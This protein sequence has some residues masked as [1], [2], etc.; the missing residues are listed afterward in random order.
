[1][2]ISTESDKPKLTPP[3]Q[4]IINELAKR[5]ESRIRRA[6]VY[7]RLQAYLYRH[8]LGTTVNLRVFDALLLKGMVVEEDGHPT[9]WILSK[10][11][12]AAAQPS[13]LTETLD[14]DEF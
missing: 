12:Q 4:A 11:G 9:Y 2:D 8:P 3:Q 5:P 6:V 7:G 10:S 13:T 1:M 14:D